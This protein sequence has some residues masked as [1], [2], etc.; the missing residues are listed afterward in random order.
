MLLLV[1]SSCVFPRWC[2]TTGRVGLP[3]ARPPDTPLCFTRSLEKEDD[4]VRIIT[5][6]FLAVTL[7][8][9]LSLLLLLLLLFH[10]I[11]PT[12]SP[13]AAGVTSGAG[14]LSHIHEAC[15]IPPLNAICF[16]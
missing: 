2:E 6:Q 7:H 16:P 5:S 15:H 14:G 13:P 1:F 10:S 11:S 4:L 8:R 9:Q 3:A 12:V